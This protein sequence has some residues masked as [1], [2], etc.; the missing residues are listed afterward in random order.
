MDDKRTSFD[1]GIQNVSSLDSSIDLSSYVPSETDQYIEEDLKNLAESLAPRVTSLLHSNEEVLENLLSSEQKA[2]QEAEDKF[3]L[4][5]SP[6]RQLFDGGNDDDED[7]MD[8]EW[9]RLGVA[10]DSLREELEMSDAGLK[11]MKDQS[12]HVSESSFFSDEMSQI[13]VEDEANIGGQ[14]DLYTS[15]SLIDDE[16]SLSDDEVHVGF[17]DDDDPDSPTLDRS[18]Q[19]DKISDDYDKNN[20]EKTT[21]RVSLIKAYLKKDTQARSSQQRGSYTLYD[22]AHVLGLEFNNVDLGY[23]SCPLLRRKDVK[24]LLAATN[25]YS[26]CND[27]FSMPIGEDV[28]VCEIA[29]GHPQQPLSPVERVTEDSKVDEEKTIMQVMQCT[30]EYIKPM[31]ETAL[32][33]IFAGFD[34]GN[35]CSAN[36]RERRMR[37][38][39]N[40]IDTPYTSHDIGEEKELLPIRTVTIR[41]RP[42]IL[43][44][45]VMD[46]AYTAVQSIG[47]EVIKRQGSHL[48]AVV[49]GCCIPEENFHQFRSDESFVSYGLGSLF[50]PTSSPHRSR[51]SITMLPP[52]LIDV[53]LCI[54]RRSREGERLILIRSFRMEEGQ[55]VEGVGC[56]P[57][58]KSIVREDNEDCGGTL[59]RESAA[60]FQRIRSVAS[61]GGTIALECNDN[62]IVHQEGNSSVTPPPKSTAQQFGDVIASP[63]RLFASEPKKKTSRPLPRGENDANKR[64]GRPMLRSRNCA[65]EFTSDKL[66][67]SFIETPSIQCEQVDVEP[68]AALSVDDWPFV[69]S[70]WRFLKEFLNELDN[71][72][73][74]YGTLVSCPFGAFPALPTIDV[75]YCSQMKVLCR[76]NMISSL[77]SAAQELEQFAKEAE[78]SCAVLI[79]ALRPSFNYYR[80]DAPAIPE[81]IPLTAYPL[82][83]EAPEAS[84]WGH[85]VIAALNRVAVGSSIHS[86][87]LTASPQK[88]SLSSTDLINSIEKNFDDG[89]KSDQ[90]PL[91]NGGQELKK[92]EFD[93]AQEAVSIVLSA[94]HKQ[95]DEELSARLCRKNVQVMDRLAKMQAHKRE[96]IITIRDS[97]GSNLF[98]NKEADRLHSLV[99]NA[100]LPTESEG[101]NQLSTFHPASDQ[102]PLMTSRILLGHSHGTCYVTADQMIL[103]TQLIPIIGGSNVQVIPLAEIEVEVNPASKSILNPLP[104][105]ILVHQSFDDRKDTVKFRPSVGPELFKEFIDSVKAVAAENSENLNFSSS[106]GLLYMFDEKDKVAKAAL[107]SVM[108]I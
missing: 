11:F 97:Y 30:R 38:K 6:G 84:S 29:D 96:S 2:W 33:K 37:E 81:P 88:A 8:A 24:D 12:R 69:Q 53:Q 82:D 61:V 74:A 85:T 16:D 63:M 106:G 66:M 68:I 22:H 103:V 65:E 95:E 71:R 4:H 50:S 54:R 102:V 47:G 64:H 75:H 21:S 15:K 79:Q 49:P 57:I 94:F 90:K 7:G 28:Q 5:I 98:V 67:R 51:K 44:G 40:E 55:V 52:F 10:E 39:E 80:L 105:S 17:E 35:N 36:S 13:E 19:N 32:A 91:C 14:Q 45:A 78:Y 46:A 62:I 20:N 23:P 58:E 1:S 48:R 92:A 83:Y 25:L 72:D 42:D 27:V 77:V 86:E 56:P 89:R 60:L 87:S 43:C 101:G 104:A 99:Q 3:Q 18:R 100:S 93:R 70:T 41:I 76:D 107:G 59:V 9:D 108:P 34:S 31:K 73:L 26:E